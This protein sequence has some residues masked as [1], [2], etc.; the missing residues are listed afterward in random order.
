MTVLLWLAPFAFL[1]L[2]SPLLLLALPFALTR[3]LSDS[4][5]HWGPAFHYSAPLAPVLA[6][7]AADGLARLQRHIQNAR[8]TRRGRGAYAAGV[9]SSQFRPCAKR[10]KPSRSRASRS[11]G[12]HAVVAC[13]QMSVSLTWGLLSAIVVTAVL[14]LSV[15]PLEAQGTQASPPLPASLERIRKE[16][17]KPPARRLK[18]DGIQTS[19]PVFRATV[20]REDV[21]S[22]K[23][24]LEKEFR[25]ND[26]QRQSQ[27][28]SS[29]CCGL[30][31]IGLVK[32]VDKY[33]KKREARKIREQI[34]RELAQIEAA[35]K[36]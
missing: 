14:L 19:V 3:F 33:L 27:E 18:L 21:P 11:A 26:F 12:D 13:V 32:G 10:L 17:A 30:D 31:L 35:S 24:L 29:K 25:L 9:A 20:E 34:A 8:R 6:L 22:F 23:A 1:P 5:F 4:P 28:W 15:S 2:A 36:K 7:A 16:L